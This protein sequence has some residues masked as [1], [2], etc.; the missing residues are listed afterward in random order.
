MYPKCIRNVIDCFK[1]L[2]GIGEKTA[3]RLAFSLI[4]FSKE[5]LTSFSAAITDIRDKIT[6]CEICGNIADSNICNICSDKE[7]NSNI[8]FVVEK[9][10]DISLFEKINIYNGK[11]HVLGGLISPLDGI[12]PDD[13]N[14]N[15]LIDR[16]DKESVHEIIMAL[17]PSIEGETTMQYIKKILENKNVRVTRI[18]TGI[19]MGTDI[20]YIDAMTLEFALEG[21]KDI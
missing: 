21:R 13:I 19:P 7:R 2:P 20:E 3:E 8:I 17:K 12:G 14:I 10:K 5:N 9:A 11:Y 4:G 1:N 6:T 18:A 16:I 15:K